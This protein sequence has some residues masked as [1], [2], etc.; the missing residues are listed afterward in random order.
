MTSM[1]EQ[2]AA[3]EVWAEIGYNPYTGVPRKQ[4]LV[5]PGTFEHSFHDSF[6]QEYRE[7]PER[8]EAEEVTSARDESNGFF[9]NFVF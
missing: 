8:A 1:T 7:A 6:Y 4:R 9:H 5:H 3:W 2:T